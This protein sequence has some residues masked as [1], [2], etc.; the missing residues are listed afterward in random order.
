MATNP[1]IEAAS[2]HKMWI[3][4]YKKSGERTRTQVWCFIHDG[5]IEFLTDGESLK[6]KRLK[7]NPNVICFLGSNDGPRIEGTAE[8]VSDSTELQRG[9]AAYWKTHPFMMVIL[10]MTIRSHI[11]SGRQVMVRI[12]ASGENPLAGINNP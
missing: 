3:G 8:I 5:K 11:K 9:Y 1:H 6:V 4:T 2:K 12:T 10:W 7:R